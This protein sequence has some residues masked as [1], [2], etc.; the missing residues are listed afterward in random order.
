D[1]YPHL[2]GRDT[3]LGLGLGDGSDSAGKC[4]R[5]LDPDIGSG[6]TAAGGVFMKQHS[7]PWR[8]LTIVVTTIYVFSLELAGW[9]ALIATAIGIPLAFALERYNFPGKAVIRAVALGP[10]ILPTLV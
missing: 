10:L 6:R 8:T 1:P 2:H 9:T 5:P 3:R 7:W 4:D